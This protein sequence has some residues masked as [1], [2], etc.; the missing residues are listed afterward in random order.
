MSLNISYYQTPGLAEKAVGPRTL[1]FNVSSPVKING[2][3]KQI[4]AAGLSIVSDRVGYENSL[5]INLSLAYLIPLANGQKLQ[6]AISP[7]ILQKGY[8][9][10]YYNPLQ[11][12]DPLIPSG[13]TSERGFDIGAGVYYMNP[14]FNNF[15]AGISSTHLNSPKFNYVTITGGNVDITTQSHLYIMAGNS[16]YI[17]GGN[18]VFFAGGHGGSARRPSR[19]SGRR[20]GRRRPARGRRR[21]LRGLHR[22]DARRAAG[23]DRRRR[24]GGA[25]GSGGELAQPRRPLRA[26]RPRVSRSS[27]RSPRRAWPCSGSS[28]WRGPASAMSRTW[29]WVGA[30]RAAA[31]TWRIWATTSIPGPSSPCTGRRSRASTRV[32]PAR[33]WSCPRC[34]SPSYEDAPHNAESLLID[35]GSGELFVITKEAAGQPSAVYRL[36]T[37]EPDRINLA[38]KVAVLTV[39]RAG[40]LPATAAS[41]H[42][43]GAG[44]LLRT[45]NT[46]YEFRVPA[47]TPLR[48]AFSAIP[49]PVPVGEEV[50]GEAVSYRSRRPRLLHHQ[51]G[52][53]A[54]RSPRLLPAAVAGIVYNRAWP[55]SRGT[56]RASPRRERAASDRALLVGILGLFLAEVAGGAHPG[57]G[58]CPGVFSGLGAPAR[59]ARAGARPGG[60]VGG[61]AGIGDRAGVR[62]GGVALLH[63][64]DARPGEA[65]AG[66]GIRP[67]LP[68]HA[69]VGALEERLDLLLGA[70]RRAPRRRRAV[71]RLG[72]AA[73]PADRGGL[74]CSP[75]RA[76]PRPSACR[77]SSTCVP[78]PLGGRVNDGL[79]IFTSLLAPRE[80]WILHLV[81]P[82]LLRRQAEPSGR[83]PGRRR[84]APGCGPGRVPR[85]PAPAGLARGLSGR[86]R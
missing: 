26:Q 79:G 34:A 62:A 53:H 9:G 81:A 66:R 38:S 47:G 4:G 61:L 48:Q 41:A 51:R 27:S 60:A 19:R 73:V 43:C 23:P 15:Y 13:A 20:T 82:F 1:A 50:Q 25:V 35:P 74:A 77:S 70:G 75:C 6:I 63:R 44:F 3:Q 5:N 56:D 57:A 83:G 86:A 33:T 16:M 67:A 30:R 12:L 39:P 65:A 28:R 54:P 85:R 14:S 31:S 17:R 52:R 68:A 24:S 29:R 69:G 18:T 64:G 10:K 37:L 8:D 22:V 46:L 76:W 58:G 49:V 78:L 59:G 84:A 80:A 2:G 7:G 11:P 72:W 71:P 32:G 40:D 42:P 55:T 21:R 36:Q 45:G